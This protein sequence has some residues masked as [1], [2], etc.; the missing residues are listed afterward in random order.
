M[1]EA[2]IPKIIH[3][4]WLGANA[5]P[6]EWIATVKDFADEYGY[7]YK[8]WT[9]KN[10]KTL[11]WNLVPGLKREYAKFA[12]EIA[13]RADIVR[14][15]ALYE[16]GGLYIDADSVVMKPAKLAKFLEKNKASVFFGWQD[17]TPA[18]TRKIGDLGPELRGTKRLVMNG[19]FASAPKHPFLNKLFENIVENSDRE[20]GADAWRRVGP[21]LV[22]R[23]YKRYKK[24]FPDVHVYPMKYFYPVHWG[25][26]KDPELHKKIKIPAESML[27]QYGYSTNK[28]HKFF[29]RRRDTRK[30]R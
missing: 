3:Q 5:E 19:T 26:I 15:L 29:N 12:K 16:F 24:D 20:D 27:F 1:P 30:R 11:D 4:I 21:L 14:L 6:T 9:E 18:I 23:V 8:L 22:S 13:G 7:E 10:I 25:G 28:F 2:A 17:L